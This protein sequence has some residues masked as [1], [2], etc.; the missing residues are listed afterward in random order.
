MKYDKIVRAG[1]NGCGNIIVEQILNYLF[2]QENIELDKSRGVFYRPAVTSDKIV[3]TFRYLD[4]LEPSNQCHTP[5]IGKLH[6]G[7]VIPMRDFRSAL[8]SQMRKRGISPTEASITKIYQDLFIMMYKEMHKYATHFCKR[9]DVLFLD[10]SKYFGNLDYIVDELRLFLD[11]DVTDKQRSEIHQKFSLE[12]N[13]RIAKRMSHWGQMDTNSGI[14][15]RHIGTGHPESWK[16]FFP[17]KLHEFVT[18]LMRAELTTYGWE[19]A[20]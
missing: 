6:L 10:Y 13:R 9:E 5:G 19:D 15:G 16:T 2:G 17:M 14:H 20:V 3:H 12:S 7:I 4:N 8:A 1:I 11:I 18:D